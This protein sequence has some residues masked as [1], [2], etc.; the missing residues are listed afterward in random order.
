ME[1]R[2]QST[3][4]IPTALPG[5]EEDDAR[6]KLLLDAPSADLEVDSDEDDAFLEEKTP[7]TKKRRWQ[8]LRMVA[9]FA[10]FALLLGFVVA[11]FFRIGWFADSKAQPVSRTASNDA[12]TSPAT[13]DEKLKIALSMVA[14]NAAKSNEP[15]VSRRDSNETTSTGVTSESVQLPID[16]IPANGGT[17]SVTAPRVV[18]PT[19]VPLPSVTQPA[20][21][22]GKD[23]NLK[24]KSGSAT[25]AKSDLSDS[26]VGRSLFFGVVRKPVEELNRQPRLEDRAPLPLAN[27]SSRKSI[28]FGTLLPVRLVGSIYTLRNSGGLVRMELTRPVEGNDYSYPAGTTIVG[29]IRGG[30]SVRAFVTIV[31]LIDPV[32]GELVKFGGELLGRDGSS[33]IE[34][35]RRK[36]T[37]QWARFFSGLKETASSIAGSI[38]A[39]RSGGTVI[40]SEPIRK[41]S[42]SISQDVSG[43]FLGNGKD[44]DTF[45][46]V[47]AGANGYV[48]VT[49]LPTTKSFG[50][51]SLKED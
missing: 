30:E 35:K 24:G 32:S 28:A 49:D 3:E 43:A 9:G 38:G 8:V 40:L 6:E 18:D 11:W 17:Q 22:I 51:N 7:K 37:S 12:A 21:Q 39:V 46:E 13:G 33:G 25:S 31:G 47:S 2:T 19:T 10:A 48:L 23:T 29:N 20:P 26:A 16:N 27:E 1:S 34:G 50:A 5:S 15:S 36:L 41:G 42:E 14:A 44:T 45:I 4:E